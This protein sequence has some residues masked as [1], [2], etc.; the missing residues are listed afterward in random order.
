MTAARSL[1]RTTGATR[2]RPKDEPTHPPKATDG[3]QA[4]TIAGGGWLDDSV[5]ANPESELASMKNAEV[6]ATSRMGAQPS[7]K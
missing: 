3:N 5:P 1:L 2:P 4:S 7:N 6:A